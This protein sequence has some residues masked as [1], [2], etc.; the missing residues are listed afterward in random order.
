MLPYTT[1]PEMQQFA[2]AFLPFMPSSTCKC[3]EMTLMVATQ[4]NIK[5]YSLH[6]LSYYIY[7]YRN[8]TELVN[9]VFYIWPQI[10]ILITP[11]LSPLAVHMRKDLFACLIHP[12]QSLVCTDNLQ[13]LLPRVTSD[14]GAG[15]HKFPPP[16]GR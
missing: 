11:S 1:E 13:L 10:L 15:S 4:Y 6:I 5:T 16:G 12:C 9:P 2:E 14:H 8:R 7:S 3:E